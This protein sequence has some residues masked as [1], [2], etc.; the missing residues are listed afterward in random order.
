MDLAYKKCCNSFVV[1]TQ[2]F[3]QCVNQ[4]GGQYN[5]KKGCGC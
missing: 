3:I 1:G 4:N 5:I 2:Q